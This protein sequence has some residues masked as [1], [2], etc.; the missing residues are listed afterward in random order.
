MIFEEWYNHEFGE[1]DFY[2]KLKNMSAQSSLLI[3]SLSQNAVK[4][5]HFPDIISLQ[6]I[7]SLI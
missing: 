5:I 7:V 3:K 2:M 6:V 4:F 1:A